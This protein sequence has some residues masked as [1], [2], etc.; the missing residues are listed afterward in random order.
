MESG[1]FIRITSC[2]K[3]CV[4]WISKKWIPFAWEAPK[5]DP[6]PLTGHADCAVNLKRM[7]AL[8][9]AIICW[10]KNLPIAKLKLTVDS[11]FEHVV[12]LTYVLR[13]SAYDWLAA[14]Q[15]KWCG[16]VSRP[17]KQSDILL[18]DWWS[19]EIYWWTLALVNMSSNASKGLHGRNSSKE[20]VYLNADFYFGVKVEFKADV[21]SK[22]PPLKLIYSTLCWHKIMMFWCHGV[23]LVD[24]Y[25]RPYQSIS[26]HISHISKP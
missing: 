6:Y 5:I 12:N 20:R 11:A 9:Q 7:L 13:G 1:S 16:I 18:K 21:S 2:K 26:A 10:V 3:K 8:T 23:L 19:A 24:S 17:G 15:P 25:I 14:N 22:G 4:G